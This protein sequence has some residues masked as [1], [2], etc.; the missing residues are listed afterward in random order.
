MASRA[1]DADLWSFGRRLTCSLWLV[2]SAV[3]ITTVAACG[4]DESTT[5]ESATPPRERLIVPQHSVDRLVLGMTP[6]QV[7]RAYGKPDVAMRSSESETG[8]PISEWRYKKRQITAQFRHVNADHFSLA[9]VATNSASQRTATGAGV[10]DSERALTRKLRG[11]DCGPADP[12]Q[13]WCTLGRGTVG[14]RQTLFVVRKDVVTEVR[15]FI[16]FP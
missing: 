7:H 8:K 2:V 1:L 12:G 3:L 5:S 15:T 4:E 9:G 13:R 6:T 14:T 11:L 16:A 10:G